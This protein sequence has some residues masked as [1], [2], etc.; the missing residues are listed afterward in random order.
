MKRRA[1]ML[2]KQIL[3]AQQL[4]EPQAM[5]RLVME[6]LVQLLVIAA[7]EAVGNGEARDG[8]AHAATGNS[9]RQGHNQKLAQDGAGHA[10]AGNSGR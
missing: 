7:I 10:A 9:S 4:L 6:F 2:H 5:K 8:A 1:M 3:W